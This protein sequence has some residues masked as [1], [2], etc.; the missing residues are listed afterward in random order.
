MTPNASTGPRSAEGKA[1]SSMNALKSGI[2]ANAPVLPGEDPQGR[3]TLFEE[4]CGRFNPTTPE[5]LQYVETL[6]HDAWI[7]RRLRLADE[8][9]TLEALN[10]G[11]MSH[12]KLPNA[13]AFTYSAPAQVRLQYRLNA[14]E[15]SY[16]SALHEL[17]RLKKLEPE[18]ASPPRQIEDTPA[19]TPEAPAPAGPQPPVPIDHAPAAAADSSFRQP[20]PKPPVSDRQPAPGSQSGPANPREPGLAPFHFA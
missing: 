15:R 5:Q 20:D 19:A 18:P 12:S 2:Y 3:I 4:Y 17:E 1:A 7:L 8:H 9:L 6:V 14:L 11:G 16:K 13:V 10:R